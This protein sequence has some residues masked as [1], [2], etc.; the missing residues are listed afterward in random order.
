MNNSGAKWLLFG[1]VVTVFSLTL[2]FAALVSLLIEVA[3]TAIN[4]F[5]REGQ[6]IGIIVW[7]AVAIGLVGLGVAFVG[8][9]RHD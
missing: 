1:L 5:P 2:V 4:S 8:I 3:G 7:V 6:S 9:A